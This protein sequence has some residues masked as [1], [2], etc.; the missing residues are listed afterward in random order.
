MIK[1]G[2]AGLGKMGQPMAMRLA[3]AGFDL[4]VYN[5]S[6]SRAEPLAAAGAT[7]VAEPATA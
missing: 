5:R 6:P 4:A 3:E 7:V 1:V 2:F